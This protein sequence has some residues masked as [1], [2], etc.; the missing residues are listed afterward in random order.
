MDAVR[1]FFPRLARVAERHDVDLVHVAMG[2][3]MA[4]M[5][6]P[7]L[8]PVGSRPWEVVFGTAVA[9]FVYDAARSRIPRAGAASR[10]SIH[11]STVA[12]SAPSMAAAWSTGASR[13]WAL[14]VQWSTPM[15]LPP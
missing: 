15:S 6:V 9:W 13:A 1:D 7:A 5:L 10:R 12:R 8:D 4:G 11:D 3:S 14:S 2:V